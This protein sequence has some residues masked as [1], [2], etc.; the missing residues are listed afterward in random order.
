MPDYIQR[1]DP[2]IVTVYSDNTLTDRVVYEPKGVQID[3]NSL[4]P[5]PFYADLFKPSNFYAS[6]QLVAYTLHVRPAHS[7]PADSRIV[8]TMPETLTFSDT[9]EVLLTACDCEIDPATNVIK[10]TNIF[11]DDFIGGTQ[12]KFMILSGTNP[13]GSRDAGPWSIVSQL[14]IDGVY[15][16]RDG[17]TFSE[18]FFALSGQVFSSLEIDNLQASSTDTVYD[19]TFL[20]ESDIPPG[21]SLLIKFPTESHLP[22]DIEISATNMTLIAQD[23]Q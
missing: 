13:I 5:G 22:E 10:L 15:Y 6:A 21:G 20:T 9:C 4:I 17:Q 19:F 8:I 12:L 7:L 11:E 14:L 2:I 1:I 23:S 3:Y 18:S 16:T